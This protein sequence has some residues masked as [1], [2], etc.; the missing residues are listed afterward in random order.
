MPIELFWDDDEQ[1][2]LLCVFNG[3]WE[4]DELRKVMR[5]VDKITQDREDVSAIVDIQNNQITA[6]D[7][8]NQS[9]LDFAKEIL[10]FGNGGSG[11]I[12]IVGVNQWVRQIFDIMRG[13]NAQAMKT[14]YFAD[15]LEEA[16]QILTD[17]TS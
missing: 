6:K 13:I 9:G 4:L 5:T 1:T 12:A 14:V 17:K 10:K 15:T 11:H 7:L 8:L 16:Q 2:R 3:R